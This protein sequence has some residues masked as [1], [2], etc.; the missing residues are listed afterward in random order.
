LSLGRFFQLFLIAAAA[1]LGLRSCIGEPIYIATASMEPT[2]PVGSHG[3]L[4]KMTLRLREPRRGEVI[5]FRSPFEEKGDL[6][7]RVIALPGDTVELRAK[8]VVLN[9]QPLEEPYVVHSRADEKLKGDDLGPLK[10]PDGHF[11]VLGDNRDESNDS[12]VWTDPKT[13]QAQ[14]FVD[15]GE[16]RGLLRGGTD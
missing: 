10:V 1:T 14:P 13:G 11:F 12:S 3:F 6:V 2:L 4:D 15:S 7:K 8:K 16:V 5:V 9:G